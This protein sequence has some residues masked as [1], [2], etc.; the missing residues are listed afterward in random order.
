MKT[1]Q[2]IDVQIRTQ[3]KQVNFTEDINKNENTF[4]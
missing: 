3:H 2:Y 4:F 1:P